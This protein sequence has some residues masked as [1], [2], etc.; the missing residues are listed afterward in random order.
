M[1]DL[2]ITESMVEHYAKIDAEAEEYLKRMKKQVESEDPLIWSSSALCGFLELAIHHLL[3]VKN[4]YPR[5]CFKSIRRNNFKIWDEVVDVID[6]LLSICEDIERNNTFSDSNIHD[7]G[8]DGITFELQIRIRPPLFLPSVAQNFPWTICLDQEKDSIVEE[9]PGAS[10]EG[11]DHRTFSVEDLDE[12]T[13]YESGRYISSSEGVWQILCFPIHERFPPV[14]HLSVH[15][16]KGQKVYFTE[17]NAIH[18]IINPQK[19]TLMAFFELC[20]VN[21]FSKILLYCKVPAYFV[22]NN[23][24]YGWKKGKAVSGYLEI[25]KDQVLGSM[26]TVHPGNTECYYL[27]LLLHK[28]P[29]PTSFTALKTIVGVVKPSF[30]AACRVLGLLEDDADWNSTLKETSI[31]E[32][33][34]K[35][36]ELFAIIL[37]FSPA[38]DPIKLWE[39]YRDSL[40]EDVKKQ[41]KAYLDFYPH[42]KRQ[43]L[44]NRC[45]R[46]IAIASSGIAAT[47]IDGGKTAHSAFKLP[48]NLHHSES[49][50]C[51]IS[52]QSDMVHVLREAKLIIWDECTMVHKKDIEAL[53]RML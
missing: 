34:N 8:E 5:N 2:E 11:T 44:C 12:V 7:Q 46:S 32:S 51:N 17:D 23:K 50:N 9:E 41:I 4:V 27:H 24:F 49:V 6:R 38:G 13:R 28:I 48:L 45:E 31:S 15:L 18:K 53:N 14:M 35:I 16:K 36:R 3:Y 43:D 47:L 40:S 42:H 1:N 29:G 25:K 33:P 26:Y 21:N 39:K 19:A 22:W 52:E 30:Q 37:V 20:E 10:Y